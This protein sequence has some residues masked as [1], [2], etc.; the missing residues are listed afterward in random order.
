MPSSPAAVGAWA[1][2]RRSCWPTGA[3]VVVNDLPG[4][5]ADPAGSVV[6]QIAD[7]GG[8]A[9]A[10]RCSVGSFDGGKQ[11][12]EAALD[13]YGGLDILVNSAGTYSMGPV[14]ALSEDDWDRVIDVNLKGTFATTRRA[15]TIFQKQG[16]GSIINLSSDAGLGDYFSGVYSA[17]KEGVVGLTRAVAREYGRW[18]VRCNAIRP[19]AFDTGMADAG[20]WGRQHHFDET[21]G[22]PMTGTHR[23]TPRTGTGDEVAAVV[24]WLCTDEAAHVNGRVI[25]AGCGEIGLW[26]ESTVVRSSYR[27]EGLDLAYVTDVSA[28]IFGELDDPYATLPSDAMALVDARIGAQKRRKL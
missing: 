11:I 13:T 16:S 17:S 28:H 27:S 24:A 22:R 25:Q 10:V 6:A 19:R 14:D 9:V 7:L 2:S 26:S 18:G 15:V 23:Y 21:Y 1:S 12:V 8:T 3:K 20:S 5:D 4:S